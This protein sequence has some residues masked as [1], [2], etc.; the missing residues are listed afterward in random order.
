MGRRVGA[1]A[2]PTK[3][4]CGVNYLQQAGVG[5]VG[6]VWWCIRVSGAA[7]V[8][9]VECEREEVHE[10]GAMNRKKSTFIWL[11]SLER[12]VR[13]ELTSPSSSFLF[14]FDEK[15][16]YCFIF[17]CYNF[18]GA[19]PPL[20]RLK[21]FLFWRNWFYLK[22]L[23]YIRQA[24]TGLSLGKKGKVRGFQASSVLF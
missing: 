15:M 13:H 5:H 14:T 19:G 18:I 6:D 22:E 10:A 4:H 16:V 2:T 7:A 11:M 24:A 12:E 23:P 8:G 21:L 9:Q 20:Y 3:C 1:S 17:L